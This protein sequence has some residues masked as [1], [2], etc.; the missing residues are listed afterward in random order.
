MPA[1]TKYLNKSSWHQFAKISAGLIGG[2]LITALLHMCLSL[3]LPHH[4]EVLITSIIT[5][6]IVWCALLIIP[7]L[8][9][10]GWKPWLIY[11]II[12]AILLGIYSFANQHNPFTT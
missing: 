12:I 8:F 4:K 6:F 9:V 5:L 3:I 11:L 10:N 7:F 2:Y 1:N